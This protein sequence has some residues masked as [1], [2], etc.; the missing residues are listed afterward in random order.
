MKSW[1]AMSKQKFS[2]QGNGSHPEK[3]SEGAMVLVA[4]CWNQVFGTK[5]QVQPITV[6]ANVDSAMRLTNLVK[7]H[8]ESAMVRVARC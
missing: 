5:F 7:S 2:D 6:P 1:K 4:G 3:P 8:Y